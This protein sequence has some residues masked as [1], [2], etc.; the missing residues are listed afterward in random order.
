[1]ALC[2]L[3][4]CRKKCTRLREK[5]R[6]CWQSDLVVSSV[7]YTLHRAVAKAAT[8][9]KKR[10]SLQAPSRL[11]SGSLTRDPRTQASQCSTRLESVSPL[12]ICMLS[13][14]STRYIEWVFRIQAL[15][16]IAKWWCC[17]KSPD[18]ACRWRQIQEIK[19]SVRVGRAYQIWLQKR[20]GKVGW[21]AV[22]WACL[23]S[24]RARFV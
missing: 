23:L 5:P 15:P 10:S 6:G 3:K 16:V 8:K 24:W 13:R 9:H 7:P 18:Q 11:L 12:A 19:Y 2:T 17:N 14:P 21:P 20:D 1:M 4:S 22:Q